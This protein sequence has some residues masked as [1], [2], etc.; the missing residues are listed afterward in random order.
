MNIDE[1][2]IQKQYI[3]KVKDINKN[4]KK[5]YNILTMGCQLNE[6]DS[7][8]LAGMLTEMGYTETDDLNKANIYN[9]LGET[10]H[11]AITLLDFNTLI[12]SLDSNQ[13]ENQ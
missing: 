4:S 3:E 11:K 7:E 5:Y 12:T 10:D 8:K 9:I 6:N 2:K 1:V 13:G